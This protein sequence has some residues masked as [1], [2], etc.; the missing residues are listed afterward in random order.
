MARKLAKELGMKPCYFRDDNDD[1]SDNGCFYLPFKNGDHSKLFRD[2]NSDEVDDCCDCDGE[3]SDGNDG[4][5]GD[6]DICQSE[7][8]LEGDAGVDSNGN[9]GMEHGGEEDDNTDGGN[10]NI[11]GIDCDS[12]S[13]GYDMDG[14]IDGNM[15]I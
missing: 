15:Q 11:R 13:K 14:G 8:S 4:D 7:C 9:S 10:G 3:E 6:G 2:L 1:D 5:G 12:S